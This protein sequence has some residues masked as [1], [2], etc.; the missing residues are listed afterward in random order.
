VLGSPNFSVGFRLF[1]NLFAGGVLLFVMSFLVSMLVPA[2]VYVLELFV[3]LIQ[4]FVFSMLLLIFSSV[5]MQ[6]HGSE[7]HEAEH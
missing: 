5:A 3:G 6:G 7:H 2:A 1:G 4:A